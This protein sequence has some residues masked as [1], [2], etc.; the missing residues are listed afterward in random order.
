MTKPKPTSKKLLGEIAVH[1]GY[2]TKHD[3]AKA[4]DIQK[5]LAATG[6]TKMLGL[7]LLEQAMIDNAQFIDL[8]RELDHMVHDHPE[9]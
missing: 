1:K 6:R 9:P 3:V 2:C 8:L 7:I 5:C 4:L